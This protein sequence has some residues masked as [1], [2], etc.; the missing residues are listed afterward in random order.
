MQPQQIKRKS[1]LITSFIIIQVTVSIFGGVVLAYSPEET[2]IYQGVRINQVDV[3]GLTK[4][5][6]FARLKYNLQLDL[7]STELKLLYGQQ[8]WLVP[9]YQF[10]ANY[11]LDKA[12]EEAAQVGH[13]ENLFLRALSNFQLSRQKKNIPVEIRFDRNLLQAQLQKKVSSINKPA[14]DAQI[15]L[16]GDQFEI[17]PEQNGVNIDVEKNLQ[18]L[19]Q[20]VREKSE[21]PVNL[22]TDIVKPRLIADDLK[23][24]KDSIA[25]FATSFNLGN[26]NRVHN[27]KL[28]AKEIDGVVVKPGEV[29]SFNDKVGQRLRKFGYK[30]APVIS[31]SKLVP[32][33]GGGVCQVSTTLYHSVLHAGLEVKERTPHSKPPTYVPL[34]QDAAVA[35]N[36]LDFKFVNTR[37]ASIYIQSEVRTDQV[38]VRFFGKKEANE[39]E[40][41]LVSEDIKVVEPKVITKKDSS[42]PLGVNK[43]VEPG[44][45]GY[46][47]KVYRVWKDNGQITKKEV[48]SNDYYRPTPTVIKVGTKPGKV[49]DGK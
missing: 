39:P 22:V 26:T 12:I 11:D 34:G 30:E 41:G 44:E 38:I 3:G 19:E 8:E 32:G 48:L 21:E 23:D 45:K 33:I 49:N 43:V 46:K 40:V 29:F 37:Q 10:K 1:L 47:V 36:L 4:E 28:A 31:N 42:L 9:F 25:V 35:D 6:A 2:A 16:V 7:E 18:L 14:N 5:A 15:T 20:R 17:K 13:Q 24:I 27:I